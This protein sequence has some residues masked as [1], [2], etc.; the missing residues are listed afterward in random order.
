MNPKLLTLSLLFHPDTRM[1]A[2][3]IWYEA[4]DASDWASATVHRVGDLWVSLVYRFD[5]DGEFTGW[6]ATAGRELQDSP[7]IDLAMIRARRAS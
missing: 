5:D 1:L 7:D 6:E 3:P 4:D 2:F